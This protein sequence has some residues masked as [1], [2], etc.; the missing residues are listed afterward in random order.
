MRTA[1][2]T[3]APFAW[4]AG[5]L[6]VAVGLIAPV[7]VVVMAARGVGGAAAGAVLGLMMVVTTA[8]E[9]P[10]GI[11]ADRVG[12]RR[13]IVLGGVLMGCAALVFAFAQTETFFGLAAV[14]FGLG[15]ALDSGALESLA[16]EVTQAEAPPDAAAARTTM[17]L[18]RIALARGIGVAAGSLAAG[19]AV[20]AARI[21]DAAVSGSSLL[22]SASAPLLVSGALL[23]AYASWATT[24]LPDGP[25]RAA[26]Q[27]APRPSILSGVLITARVPTLRWLALRSLLVAFS[28][29]AFHLVT[30]LQLSRTLGPEQAAITMGWLLA[31]TF[32]A[33]G[34][35]AA[36]A[37]Q[38]QVRWGT[39]A[40]SVLLT[41]VAAASLVLVAAAGPL[42][43]LAALLIAYFAAAGPVTTLLSTVMHASLP[44]T[45]RATAV[46]VVSVLR[47]AGGLAGAVSLGWVLGDS[48]PTPAYIAG[49]AAMLLSVVTVARLRLVQSRS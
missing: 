20:I 25:P 32:A 4:V 19:L 23:A 1:S 37:P 27:P 11:L 13:A 29:A 5:V 33:Q 43:V 39:Y 14:I 12:Y 30:P 24:C 18:S 2:A 49:A 8:A 3:P 16:V 31:A 22:V 44:S 28:M 35:G 17:V 9:V 26:E 7:Q 41:F 46:S 10:A 34:A 48:G 6:S 15:K 40:P 42:P 45:S 36:V 21:G 47:T 38:I